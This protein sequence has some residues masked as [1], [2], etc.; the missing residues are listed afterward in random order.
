MESRAIKQNYKFK[1]NNSF[2][3][4]SNTPKVLRFSKTPQNI[5]KKNII[6]N[7]N[8][9]NND[10]MLLKKN[11][12]INFNFNLIQNKNM[13]Q[14][15]I[16]TITPN[17]KLREIVNKK[18]RENNN[19][20]IGNIF[21]MRTELPDI[22]R[23]NHNYFHIRSYMNTEYSKKK[24]SNE[25]IDRQLKLIFVMKNKINELNK[26][27]KD[28]NK[29]ILILKNYAHLNNNNYNNTINKIKAEKE[30]NLNEEKNINNLYN[31]NNE[32]KEKK[33]C[34]KDKENNLKKRNFQK[35]SLNKNKFTRKLTPIM[36]SKKNEEVD[37]LNKEI[38]NLNKIIN[39]LDEKYQNEIKKNVEFNQKFTF[40]KNCTF[41]L[42]APKVQIEERIKNYENKIIDLEEQLYQYKQRETKEK[43]ILSNEEY[44]NIKICL[45]ALLL[46][47]KI[48]DKNIL[49]SN[50]Q[51]TFENIEKISNNLCDLL[52]ISNNNTINNFINDYIIKNT[53]NVLTAIT[54]EELFLYN[55]PK[56]NYFNYNLFS[57]IKER[58]IVYDYRKEGKVP[59]IYLR[60][61]YNEFCYKN[62]KEKNEKEFFDIV[63]LCKK[64]IKKSFHNNVNDIYYDNLINNVSDSFIVKNFIDSI[65]NEEI[66]KVREREKYNNLLKN[67]NINGNENNKSY[68]S[69]VNDNFNDDFII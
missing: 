58:C 42:N 45:N 41:G 56:D 38:K 3:Y 20:D 1:N 65:M 32:T 19:Y 24:E 2:I 30:K 63:Y 8:K 10:K 23:N 51:I 33:N 13:N 62:K 40:M 48:N 7:Q 4:I 22:T 15:K 53:Q 29:E 47:N 52:K 31:I 6:Q 46:L 39:D 59:I 26:V 43:I 16:R 57:F 17:L 11:P 28:K 27:I 49:T 68:N 21:K 64:N 37:K 5:D 18:F 66:E 67:K 12:Y 60:H 9:L 55:P 34:F 69:N 54:F 44:S 50:E 14:N 61:L 35:E 36:G 25:K